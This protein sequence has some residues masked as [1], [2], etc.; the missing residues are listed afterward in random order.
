MAIYQQTLEKLQHFTLVE[1]EAKT[2]AFDSDGIDLKDYDGDIL[3]ILTATAAGVDITAEFRLEESADD[4]TYAAITGGGF[5]DVENDF[6]KQV[7]VLNR[8]GLKRYVRLSMTDI[9]AEGDTTVTCIG[10]ALKKYG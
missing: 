10:L 3:V 4:V 1:T 8:D 5:T 7:K 6:S 2:A 9:T